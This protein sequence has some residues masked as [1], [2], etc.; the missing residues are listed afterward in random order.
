MSLS[1]LKR[2]PSGAVKVVSQGRWSNI[3]YSPEVFNTG[4]IWQS[5]MYKRPSVYSLS[6]KDHFRCPTRL[7]RP[8]LAVYFTG[9]NNLAKKRT[10]QGPWLVSDKCWD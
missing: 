9:I 2:P 8:G 4:S 10:V 6:L 7:R 3:Q 1:Y 5:N